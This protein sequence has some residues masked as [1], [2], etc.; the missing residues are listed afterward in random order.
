MCHENSDASS[1]HIDYFTIPLTEAQA[2]LALHH[3][4]AY[5]ESEADILSY[6]LRCRK[7]IPKNHYRPDDPRRCFLNEGQDL[8]PVSLVP[9]A[10]FKTANVVLTASYAVFEQVRT[11][12]AVAIKLPS[13]SQDQQQGGDPG[14]DS[15]Q[16]YDST[17][18][19]SSQDKVQE[20]VL[21]NRAVHIPSATGPVAVKLKIT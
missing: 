5:T 17:D 3:E 11:L 12:I 1:C 6:P 15:A 19:T 13:M 10:E 21:T 18:D 20:A 4:L 9:V 2:Q 14:G 16:E 8:Q 7:N